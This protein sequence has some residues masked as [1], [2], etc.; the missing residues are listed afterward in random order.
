MVR[1][2]IVGRQ[3]AREAY[4]WHRGF[5]ANYEFIFPRPWEKYESLVVDRQIWC[6]RNENGDFLASAY[7]AFDEGKWEIGGVMVA[8]PERGKGVAGVL[9][10]LTL[11]HVLVME[12]PLKRGHPIIA[13]IHADNQEPRVLFTQALKFQMPAKPQE[14]PGEHL[15]GLKQNDRGKVEGFELTFTIPDTLNALVEWFNRWKLKLKDGREACVEL[16]ED[17]TLAMWSD[18]LRDM[19]EGSK[20]SPIL[21]RIR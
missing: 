12:T 5:A 6:A 16:P 15:P 17:F 1:F 4:Q 8:K 13:H 19:A 18:A 14:F 7:F 3:D 11:A 21:P 20:P 2:G 10:R 9:A